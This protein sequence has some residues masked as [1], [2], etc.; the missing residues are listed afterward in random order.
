MYIMPVGNSKR[1]MCSVKSDN[2]MSIFYLR[3]VYVLVFVTEPFLYSKNRLLIKSNLSFY[4]DENLSF[5]LVPFF[6]AKNEIV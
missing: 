6:I 5:T 1:E 4:S 3:L 2:R